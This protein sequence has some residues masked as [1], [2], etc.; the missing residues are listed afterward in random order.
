MGFKDLVKFNEAMLAKQVW[1]LLHDQNCVLSGPFGTVFD[2]KKSSGSY[3]WQ[4]ILKAR[5][6]IADGM[7]WRVGD[8]STIR[9]YWDKWLPGKFPSRIGSPQIVTPGD[10]R[11]SSLI[12]QDTK[13]W[14]YAR[15]DHLF[16]PFEAE[17][18]K[19]IPVCHSPS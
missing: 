8:G 10:V 11:V 6:V 13:T 2:A 17:K 5:S 18:I 9:I 7:L 16:L 14:D 3:A 12:D 4:S 1:G 15:I 19:A